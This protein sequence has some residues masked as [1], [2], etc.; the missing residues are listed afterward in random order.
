MQSFSLSN[1]LIKKLYSS[2]EEEERDI[3]AS[4]RS[5][6]VNSSNSNTTINDYED[7]NMT[8]DKEDRLLIVENV[9]DN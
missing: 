3:A 7:E 9:D 4:R 8:R 2:N 5:Q 1:S 6:R